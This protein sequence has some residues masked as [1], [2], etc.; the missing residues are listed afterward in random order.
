MTAEYATYESPVGP[1][2]LLGDGRAVRGL[3]MQD[4]RRP[5]APDA[6]APAVAGG[7][8]DRVRDQLDEY[9]A[10]ARTTFDVP[11]AAGGTP[12]QQRVWAEL[13]RIPYGRTVT[14]GELA[15]RIGSPGAARAVGAANG[16]NPISIVVPCHRV[17][18]STGTLTGY[19][20][21]V[22]RKRFLLD[23]EAGASS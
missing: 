9:F 15:S 12:F 19:A 23:L 7:L 6:A 4:G 20:G 11:L 18:G 8:L 13:A 17:I 14:Y 22:E 1:L 2:L 16:L 21:G 10:G 5:G 3:Y